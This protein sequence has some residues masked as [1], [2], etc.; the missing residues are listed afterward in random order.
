MSN[1]VSDLGVDYCNENLAGA[2]LFVDGAPNRIIEIG[3]RTII[4]VKYH[5]TF[6]SPS[7]E[8]VNLP[9]SLLDDGFD[10]LSYP[11]LGYRALEGGKILVELDLESSFRRGLQLESLRSRVPLCL[12][13][14]AYRQN[15]NIN[16]F[17]NDS[18]RALS[19][20]AQE[21]TPLAK[22]LDAVNRGEM[23][24]FAV[25]HELA[26]IPSASSGG[27][28][29]L[30]FRGRTVG[31]LAEDGTITGTI[32]NAPKVMEKLNGNGLK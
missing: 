21:W 10:S 28:L 15:I 23:L 11:F 31:A 1:L 9:V 16:K 24:T 5:G 2:L 22:G 7:M 19:T 14:L 26:A 3:S 13:H 17:L 4:A 29:D 18:G 25:S 27:Y 30:I 20:V 8:E 32:V 6:D 12:E